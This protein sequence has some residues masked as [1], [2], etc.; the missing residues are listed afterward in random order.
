MRLQIALPGGHIANSAITKNLISFA[1]CTHTR[2]CIEVLQCHDLSERN[3]VELPNLALTKST[4][5]KKHM[6][7]KIPAVAM[8]ALSILATGCST[9]TGSGTSQSMSVQTY[10]ADGQD[11]EGVKCEMNNDEGTW[12]VLTPGSA[13]VHRSNKDLQVVCKKTGIDVGTAS[14]VSRTKGNMFGNIIFGGGIGAI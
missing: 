3:K 10:L 2:P 6:N 7:H 5:R 8:L 12:C 11:V 4:S 1:L 9:I 14:I 13:F